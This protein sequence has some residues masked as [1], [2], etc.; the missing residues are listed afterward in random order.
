MILSAR[1]QAIADLVP[2]SHTLADIGTD[3]GY[4]PFYLIRQNRIQY[5]IA[6]DI[7]EGSLNKARELIRQQNLE[8]CM[9]T[10]LGDGL[11]VLSPGEANTILIAGMGGALIREILEQGDAAARSASTL[12]LQPMIGQQELRKWLLNNGY[13]ITDEELAKEGRRIY[14]IIV[15]VSDQTAAGYEKE[16]FYDVGWKLIEKKH[17]LLKE[18]MQ[19]KIHGLEEIM[20]NLEKGKTGLSAARLQECKEKHRQYKEVYRCLIE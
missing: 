15:A 16:V 1:L 2:I 13:A 7:S 4:I 8:H 10:R 9:E 17:P 14:E 6:A 5:A 18:W 19:G 20:D 12:I 3:H 11:S